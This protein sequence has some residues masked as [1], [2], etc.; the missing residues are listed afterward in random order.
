MIAFAAQL[1]D[2]LTFLPAV[3]IYGIS[4]EGNGPIHLF[5]EMAGIPGIAALKALA[6]LLIL[7]ALVWISKSRG[8]SLALGFIAAYGLFG[9]ATNTYA[10]LRLL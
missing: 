4:G 10:L 3:A 2:L 9:V 8:R 6:A 7:A 5:Y 1:A